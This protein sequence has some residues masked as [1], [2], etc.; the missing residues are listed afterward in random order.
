MSLDP[1]RVRSNHGGGYQYR[2]CP[3]K[4]PLTEDC[5]SRTPLPFVGR[6]ALR[7]N[8]TAGGGGGYRH[9]FDGKYV[10]EGTL[11]FGSTWAK[12]P[13][14]RNDVH[15]TRQGFAPPCDEDAACRPDQFY[16]S[17]CRCS[18]MW[19]PWQV[20]IVDSVHVPAE[21]PAGEYVLGWRWDCEESNQIWASC[22]DVTVVR[23]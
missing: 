3:A 9:W 18:G 2:L 22:S 1:P 12:N 16:A 7:W 5:F 19:G 6:Q 14:P 10:S 11:P 4:E 21:L 23:H 15:Q 17:G 8:G 20:E 13:L